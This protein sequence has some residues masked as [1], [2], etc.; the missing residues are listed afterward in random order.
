[1]TVTDF[2]NY[3]LYKEYSDE[4]LQFYLWHQDYEKRFMQAPASDTALSLEWTQAMEGETAARLQKETLE[5]ARH[6]APG[7]VGHFQ[8]YRSRSPSPNPTPSPP[9][10]RRL[11]LLPATARGNPRTPLPPPSHPSS[12]PAG[13]K[14]VV[15]LPPPV[16][17]PHV[18]RSVPFTNS[19]YLFS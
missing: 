6:D 1:M 9:H 15:L 14:V 13:H 2:M 17:R 7:V 5:N 16:S 12:T 8:G 18:R 10:H 3:L 4:N 11:A 19:I